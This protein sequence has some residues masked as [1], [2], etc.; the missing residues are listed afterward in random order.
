LLRP[1]CQDYL[2]PTAFYIAGPSEISYFAQVNCNYNLFNVEQPFIYPRATVTIIEKQIATLMSKYNLEFVD[3]LKEEKVLRNKV[4][5]ATSVINVESLF[6]ESEQ[7][8]VLLMEKIKERLFAVDESLSDGVDKSLNK[9]TQALHSLKIRSESANE[10]NNGTI[11][12]QISKIQSNLYPLDNYQ[13][14]V[15]N[16]THF[17]NK[18]GL[19]FVKWI[20]GELS[21]KDH[22]HQIIEI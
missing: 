8:L 11:T 16:W 15:L 20:Y 17:A 4:I 6:S 18:Y 7:V 19:D 10:R 21:V 1:I 3:I 12:R 9:M 14:R 2:F 22:N 5:N 13:E